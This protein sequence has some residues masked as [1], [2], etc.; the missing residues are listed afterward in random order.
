MKLAA[1]KLGEGLQDQLV[2]EC[3]KK[4]KLNFLQKEYQQKKNI[5]DTKSEKLNFSNENLYK[6]DNTGRLNL[7]NQEALPHF[8]L[9]KSGSI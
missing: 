3:F 1:K 9:A 7:E 5:A 6:Y 8:D 2:I 4:D